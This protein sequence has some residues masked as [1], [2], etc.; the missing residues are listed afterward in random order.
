MNGGRAAYARFEKIG[1]KAVGGEDLRGEEDSAITFD[2]RASRPVAT[3]ES[4]RW[5]FGDGQHA[6]SARATH[7]YDDPG[8]YTAKLTVTADG[9]SDTDEVSVR[10]DERDDGRGLYVTV[11]EENGLIAGADVVVNDSDGERFQERTSSDGRAR[12]RGLGDGR[13]SVYVN[14]PGYVPAVGQAR[15]DDGTG[16]VTIDM[17]SGEFAAVD[18]QTH[19]LSEDEI[20]AVGIDPDDPDNQQVIKT[21]VKLCFNAIGDCKNMSGYVGT[22]AGGAWYSNGD[23]MGGGGGRGACWC[24]PL[25]YDGTGTPWGDGVHGGGYQIQGTPVIVNHQPAVVWMVMPIGGGFT[26]QFYEIKLLVTNLAPDEISFEDGQATLHLPSGMS[27]APTS[28]AQS[29][30]MPVGDIAGGESRGV[31]W[32]V[33]GDAAG[34]YSPTVNYTGRLQPFDTPF[35]LSAQ[36][37]EPIRIW[38]ASDALRVVVD[39]DSQ[40]VRGEP[41][42]VRL[43]LRNISSGGQ[44]ASVYNPAVS[45][46]TSEDYIYQPRQRRSFAIDGI[47]PGQTYWTDDVILIPR[48]SGLLDVASSVVASAAGDAAGGGG[49]VEHNPTRTYGFKGYSDGTLRWKPVPGATRYEI[50]SIPADGE[51]VFPDSEFPGTPVAQSPGTEVNIPGGGGPDKWY[52]I[53]AI[54]GG[55]NVMYHAITQATLAPDKDDDGVPDDVDNCPSKANTNQ[56]DKDD[57]GIGDA[58]D[59]HDDRPDPEDPDDDDGEG[60]ET[61]DDG[62]GMPKPDPKCKGEHVVDFGP[63]RAGASCWEKVGAD[64]YKSKARIRIGGMD[65]KPSGS[66]D[67]VIDTH[68]VTL[69]ATGSAEVRFGSMVV[70][71]APIN[72]NLKLAKT[73]KVANGAML[74]GLPVTGQA[75]IQ[76]IST[77]VK[78]NA[79][80]GLPGTLGG[81]TGETEL[82]L[83]NEVG[84]RVDKLAIDI[85][86]FEIKGKLGVEAARLSY[87]RDSADPELGTWSGGAKILLPTA[88]LTR[89]AIA[90]YVT[91]T[92]GALRE[93]S[94][95]VDG[96]QL[97]LGQGVFLQRLRA[98]LVTTPFGFGGGAGI[99]FGPQVMGNEAG[100]LDGDIFLTLEGANKYEATGTLRMAE[101]TMASGHATYTTGGS[102]EFGGTLNWTKGGVGVEGNMEGWVAGTRAFN[103][104][105]DASVKLPKVS[106]GGEALLSNKGMA[107]CRRG[108]GPD[109]GFGYGWGASSP[110]IFVSSCDVGPWVAQQSL[111]RV[112][113]TGMQLPAKLPLATFAFT[114]NGAPP[115]VALTAPDGLRITTPAGGGAID[116]GRVVLFQNPADNTTY[117]AVDK[118]AGGSWQVETLPGSAPVTAS[119]HANGLP[120]P[121]VSGRVSRGRQPPQRCVIAS[122]R[123][124]A[125]PCSSPSASPAAASACSGPPA[126]PAA[127]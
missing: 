113:A 73:F 58:C 21:E 51:G 87:Q 49:V 114:G 70:W 103:A 43:G 66:G 75:T 33:R 34:S 45:L 46:G 120:E 108:F 14:A 121:Q 67:I 118:P 52:G 60:D 36:P 27:L 56:A 8:R 115:R 26:K 85:P 48:K 92:D 126:A 6:T 68:D 102:F 107:A 79:R 90:G 54:V 72:W 76:L 28:A 38:G 106:F 110:H 62:L 42:R 94:G 20:R 104:Q 22:G 98:R 78:V 109:V 97:M 116:N 91:I 77:G 1:L 69:T 117:V 99:S 37:Q 127:T 65:I 47:T 7:T 11:R 2:G 50:Y 80:A 3:I 35:A 53:S 9:E 25:A 39:A 57:D 17:A 71:R 13:Y 119:R 101:V 23:T 61:N 111:A 59:L 4:Y 12:L 82:Q 64:K 44:A 63:V 88:G 83:T 24:A 32:V 41:Y 96:L 55:R 123:S 125:R 30:T 5:D 40:A 100:S 81:V 86:G 16:A 19:E 105:G 18:V 84:L 89:T 29:L 31:D 15:V 112:A 122:S 124:P 93:L 10:V 95:E 74:K